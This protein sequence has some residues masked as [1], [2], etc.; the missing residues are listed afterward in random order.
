MIA[1][2]RHALPM[3]LRFSCGVGLGQGAGLPAGVGVSV[4]VQAPVSRLDCTSAA[5]T[6]EE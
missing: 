3:R 1:A 5:S 4:G 6:R 2:I